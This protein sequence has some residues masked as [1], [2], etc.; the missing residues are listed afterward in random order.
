MTY[1]DFRHCIH[2][3]GTGAVRVSLGLASNFADV[4]TFLRFA[5]GFV[6]D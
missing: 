5:A 6:E 4:E 2:H 1:E 3:E